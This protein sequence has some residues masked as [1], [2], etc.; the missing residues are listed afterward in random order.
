MAVISNVE[1]ISLFLGIGSIYLIFIIIGKRSGFDIVNKKVYL[2]SINYIIFKQCAG[3]IW[4]TE[5]MHWLIRPFAELIPITQSAK[6]LQG[7]AVKNKTITDKI[8]YK[9]ILSNVGWSCVFVLLT[10]IIL[11]KREGFGMK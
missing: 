11:K 8:V 1:Q 4:Q 10:L 2:N 5:A 3:M 7:L 6:A 9:G